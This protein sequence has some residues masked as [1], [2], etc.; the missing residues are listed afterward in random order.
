MADKVQVVTIG[1]VGPTG[2]GAATH[3][4][5][6]NS[7]MHVRRVTSSTRPTGLTS[8][9]KGLLIYETDTGKYM[10]WDGTLWAV[11][12]GTLG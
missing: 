1:V 3:E 6:T 12:L 7:I 2:A 9:D 5:I 11:A 10:M 4:D 8:T